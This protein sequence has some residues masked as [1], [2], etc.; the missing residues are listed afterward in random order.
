MESPSRYIACNSLSSRPGRC[1]VGDV[2]SIPC[3]SFFCCLTRGYVSCGNL[4]VDDKVEKKNVSELEK[5]LGG[6]QGWLGTV[7]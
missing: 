1:W 7:Q 3:L 4:G 6:K 2:R 5:R